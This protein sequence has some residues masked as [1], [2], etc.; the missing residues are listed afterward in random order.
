MYRSKALPT[1]Q[2]L[3]NTC[4]SFLVCTIPYHNITYNTIQ[5]NAMQCNAIQCNAMQC[6]AMQYNTMQCNAIHYYMASS[7]S[8]QGEPNRAMWLATRAS[9]MEPSCPLGTTRCIQHEKFP[10]KPYNESFI[11]QVCSVKMAGYWPR[12]FFCEFMDLDFVSVNIKHAKKGLGQYPAILTS[13]LVNNPYILTSHL[14]N[15]PYLLN[16]SS[17]IL[18]WY[19]LREISAFI[20]WLGSV[21]GQDKPN[22]ALWLAT[23]EGK[24]ELSCLLATTH[25]VPI[26]PLL[27]KLFQSRSLN[28]G[29][30]LFLQV[31]G[32]RLRLGQ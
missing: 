22:R 4:R 16:L 15:N 14:V 10:R 19:R 30:V 17:F 9:K 12:S 27:A 28:I 1:T 25:R 11:N 6:N 7:A 29:V 24:M 32:P 18:Y 8:G 13:H 26:N 3:Y 5:Y 23:R 2:F 20:I 21:S 31:Y